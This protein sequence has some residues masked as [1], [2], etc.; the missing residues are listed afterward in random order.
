M[1]QQ[2]GIMDDRHNGQQL[3]CWVTLARHR[4]TY[5]CMVQWGQVQNTRSKLQF[6]LVFELGDV[7]SGNSSIASIPL[8]ASCPLQAYLP[9]AGL[10]LVDT[11]S[12]H[13]VAPM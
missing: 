11:F 3:P 2:S 12:P 6:D 5:V 4:W 8:T 10:S 13:F 1:Q 7:Y 9:A